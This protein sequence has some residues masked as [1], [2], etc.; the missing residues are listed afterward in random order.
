LT[1]STEFDVQDKRIEERFITQNIAMSA[2]MDKRL[3]KLEHR[4]MEKLDKL[5]TTLDKFL[6]GRPQWRFAEC[7]RRPATSSRSAQAEAARI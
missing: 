2:A 4:F 1:P 7:M 6:K 5:T 3:E